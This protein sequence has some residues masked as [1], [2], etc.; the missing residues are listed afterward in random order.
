[1]RNDD[2][3]I[4]TILNSSRVIA[5][6]GHSD[7]PSRVSYQIAQFL[8][9]RDYIIYPVNP[10]ITLIDEQICYPSLKEIPE[11]IDIVN[12]FRRSE[13]VMEVVEAAI[14]IQAKT[15]WTQI[16]IYEAN[17]AQK[18]IKSGL[19]VIMDRCIKVEYLR[20]LA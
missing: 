1:M 11:P 5:V 4:K 17:A 16:G 19:N 9:K 8:K 3:Q 13:F 7:R 12:V 18:A 2:E 10:T 14:S 15:V 20:L 6:V